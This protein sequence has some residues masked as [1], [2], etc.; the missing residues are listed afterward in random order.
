LNKNYFKIYLFTI[1]PA[2]ILFISGL[3]KSKEA[4]LFLLFGGLLLTFLNWK[5]DSDWRVK[6]F[7]NKV[8]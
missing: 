4:S 7:I 8:F 1:I 6:D 5:K 2:A 3:D